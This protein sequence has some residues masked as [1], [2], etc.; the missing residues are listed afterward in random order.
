[1]GRGL[2]QSSDIFRDTIARLDKFVRAVDD[3]LR[4]YD[5]FLGE[6]VEGDSAASE[7]DAEGARAL[8]KADAAK[9]AGWMKRERSGLG[10]TAYQI[11]LTNMLRA[12]NI[13]PDFVMGHS[14][15]EVGASYACGLQTEKQ[16]IEIA[17]VRSGLSAYIRPDTFV[18]KTRTCLDDTE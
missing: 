9:E 12:S 16:T 10:I 13:N 14:L 17:I 8:D 3:S 15:G 6:E 4:I 2:M 11:G 7:N 18:L 1:M 5:W